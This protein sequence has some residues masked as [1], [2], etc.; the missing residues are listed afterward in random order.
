MGTSIC[1][2]KKGFFWQT[3]IGSFGCLSQC[4][5]GGGKNI[6][7]GWKFEVTLMR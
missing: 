3:T 4:E 7:F 5:K 2:I 1:H 6:H